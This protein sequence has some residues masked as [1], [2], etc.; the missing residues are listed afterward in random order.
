[1]RKTTIE[2]FE[3]KKA[4]R[5]TRESIVKSVCEILDNVLKT[6]KSNDVFIIEA[7]DVTEKASFHY[8]QVMKAFEKNYSNKIEYVFQMLE[9][10]QTSEIAIKVK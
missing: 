8:Y 4:S 10:A 9:N 5:K 3:A 1:M 2:A 6:S 7:K